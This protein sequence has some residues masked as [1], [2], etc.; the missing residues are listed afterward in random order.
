MRLTRSLIT[1]AMVV[2][3]AAGISAP[4]QAADADYP[5]QTSAYTTSI[6]R[7]ATASATIQDTSKG[8]GRVNDTITVEYKPESRKLVKDFGWVTKTRQ[9]TR[10]RTVNT[11]GWVRI[12]EGK[13]VGSP[14]GGPISHTPIATQFLWAG[15]NTTASGYGAHNVSQPYL[16]G[17]DTYWW[18]ANQCEGSAIYTPSYQYGGGE[19][20]A[21]FYDAATR[22]PFRPSDRTGNHARGGITGGDPL[23]RWTG[24]SGYG[25]Y[26]S[27]YR[28]ATDHYRVTG[29]YQEA[30]QVT[31][32]YDVW[33][34]TG[35]HY[36]YVNKVDPSD[37]TLENV[38]QVTLY[39]TKKSNGAKSKIA[40]T[41]QSSTDNKAS[42]TASGVAHPS[43]MRLKI[44][45]G[46]KVSVER[47]NG[48]LWDARVSNIT[49]PSSCFNT[50]PVNPDGGNS[51]RPS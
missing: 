34:Q 48:A 29:S 3:I 18:M 51:V 6:S 20:Q 32:A 2:A 26:Y 5:E 41:F 42:G 8:G 47:E 9:E 22:N 38:S 7:T 14:D 16:G 13:P 36:E 43:Q 31:V 44:T 19:H 33:E 17:G 10:Y 11:Y 30:Y 46:N 24:H 12:A 27:C 1:A 49:I 37:N 4:A 15:N 50:I 35:Q 21:G 40:A 23:M 45:S 28:W 25:W 39:C